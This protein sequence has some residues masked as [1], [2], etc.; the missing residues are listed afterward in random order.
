MF[1]SAKL[2]RRLCQNAIGSMEPWRCCQCWCADCIVLVM[3]CQP[4]FPLTESS[5]LYS[6][7]SMAKGRV[8]S[9]VPFQRV[10]QHT[11]HAGHSDLKPYVILRLSTKQFESHKQTEIGSS[12]APVATS[13]EGSEPARRLIS[14]RISYIVNAFRRCFI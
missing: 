12:R 2:S 7:H 4:T 13:C 6:P 3:N 1:L 8:L 9:Q 11:A 5:C 10:S 14:R